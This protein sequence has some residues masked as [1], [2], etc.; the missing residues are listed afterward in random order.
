MITRWQFL[1]LFLHVSFGKTLDVGHLGFP[2]SVA[3][4]RI[5]PLWELWVEGRE[6]LSEWRLDQHVPYVCHPDKA[7]SGGARKQRTVPQRVVCVL[8]SLEEFSLPLSCCLCRD[9]QSQQPRGCRASGHGGSWFAPHIEVKLVI[10]G[11]PSVGYNLLFII[12]CKSVPSAP[13]ITFWCV[14]WHKY[15]VYFSLASFDLL[16]ARMVMSCTG[17]KWF[18][19]CGCSVWGLSASSLAGC[20]FAYGGFWISPWPLPY[21]GCSN[22]TCGPLLASYSTAASSF[23]SLLRCR[24]VF[25]DVLAFSFCKPNFSLLAVL[26]SHRPRSLWVS[27]HIHFTITGFSGV[28]PCLYIH[29]YI[30]A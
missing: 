5:F 28:T 18:S 6:A 12:V 16:P 2:C 21:L 13:L 30:Q 11:L 9:H 15:C 20:A 4:I 29:T 1:Q 8:P 14:H 24:S 19:G 26:I 7:T 10:H 27:C 3:C 17:S 22:V 25:P 23:L